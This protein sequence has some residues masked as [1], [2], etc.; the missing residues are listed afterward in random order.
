MA[1]DG[2]LVGGAWLLIARPGLATLSFA[3]LSVLVGEAVDTLTRRP[4][5]A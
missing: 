4:V 1:T 5:R 3:E 2:R